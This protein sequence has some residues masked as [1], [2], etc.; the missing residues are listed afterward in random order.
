MNLNIFVINEEM[1]GSF[2][3]LDWLQ[4]IFMLLCFLR[5][6]TFLV[7]EFLTRLEEYTPMFYQI[8][9]KQIR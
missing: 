4:N 7:W 6:G 2:E 1:W 5:N 9:L 3:I 8:N